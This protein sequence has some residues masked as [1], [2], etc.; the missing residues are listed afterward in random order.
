V[1]LH[2]DGTFQAEYGIA[3]LTGLNTRT[4]RPQGLWLL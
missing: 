1:S 2:Q 4:G 3:E